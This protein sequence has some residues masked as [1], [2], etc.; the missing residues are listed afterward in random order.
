[1]KKN[2][3][4]PKGFPITA[5]QLRYANVEALDRL[6][7]YLKVPLHGSYEKLAEKL[8]EGVTVWKRAHIAV[9]RMVN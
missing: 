6:F 9:N 2:K 4:K 8:N 5:A 7:R 1:M 3:P